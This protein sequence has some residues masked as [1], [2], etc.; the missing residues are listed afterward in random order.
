M[1]QLEVGSLTISDDVE[2]RT[3]GERGELSAELTVAD[4]RFYRSVAF[5]GAL[6]AAEAYMQGYWNCG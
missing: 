5:G 6:G 3:Y 1:Q 4:S 2:K